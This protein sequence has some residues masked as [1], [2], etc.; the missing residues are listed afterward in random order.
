M[1]RCK[2]L[3]IVQFSYNPDVKDYVNSAWKLQ[4]NPYGGDVANSYNDGPPKPGK[5]QLGKFYELESSSPAVSLPHGESMHHVHRTFHLQG[6]EGSLKE[7]AKET[8]GVTL[9]Q[10][11]DAFKSK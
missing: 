11:E 4:D 5:P 7:I 9:D 10:I 3:T 6:D 2:L 8:F 1:I